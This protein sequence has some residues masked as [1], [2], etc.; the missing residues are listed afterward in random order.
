MNIYENHFAQDLDRRILP[1]E[2][3]TRSS[4]STPFLMKARPELVDIL[5]KP[6]ALM[7]IQQSRGALIIFVPDTTSEAAEITRMF[8]VQ[9]ADKAFRDED[10]HR[11]LWF[12]LFNIVVKD[13]MPW[14]RFQLFCFALS[15]P[16]VFI[17]LSSALNQGRAW[18][19]SSLM[20][21]WVASH[22]ESR[23]RGPPDFSFYTAAHDISH[24]MPSHIFRT[25]S[26]P[27]LHMLSPCYAPCSTFKLH[28]S[29]EPKHWRILPWPQSISKRY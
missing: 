27:V 25:S 12:S 15:V 20:R 26:L 19:C 10:R 2:V 23:G 8:K 9:H 1:G 11:C 24:V 18:P 4:L 7:S 28:F 17:H 14:P 6:K 13:F 16:L 29:T 22:I 5:V 21:S 3:L